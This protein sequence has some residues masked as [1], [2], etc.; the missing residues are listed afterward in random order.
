LYDENENIGGAGIYASLG[1]S[2]EIISSIV[3]GNYVADRGAF[4]AKSDLWGTVTFSNSRNVFGSDVAG[5]DPGDRENVAPS[6]IF[7]AIDPA[8]G[9]GLVN[10]A[11][12][13]PLRNSTANPALGGADPLAA[14]SAGQLGGTARPL[15][16]GSLPD[17]GSVEINQAPSTR[18]SANNDVRT[19]TSAANTLAG[20]AG[21]DLLKGLGGNDTLNGG[22]GSDLLDGGPGNDR[23][24]G[25]AAVDLVFYGG[26]SG[27]TVDLSLATDTAR[28]GSETDTL[29]NV[30]GAVGSSAGDVFRGNQFNNFFQGGA[31]RDTSTGGSGRDLYD[32]NATAESGPGSTA[33]DVV[34]DFLAGTD[35]LDL[36]GID[37][38]AGVAGDQAFRW[39][40]TAALTGAGQV[41]HFASA[42]NTIVR[43]S[44]D[45]DAASELE[46][47]LTG[48]KALT[49][50][51]FYL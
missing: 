15:P 26:S 5:N 46:V 32:I 30:E 40:G 8:T 12:I 49:A 38:D 16:A 3:A 4:I 24:N 47:Q 35:D 28:R 39:V 23:L 43:A 17:V 22:D 50:A 29:T 41:G 6:A 33:R 37:A 9:G 11:G 34:T 45:A 14:S 48:I 13:V 44:N 19:G 25:D 31:G 10:S 20:L 27:V 36:M 7:A 18:A 21:S 42:G 1:T 2:L 51:D